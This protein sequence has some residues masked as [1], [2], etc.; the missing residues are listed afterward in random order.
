MN[1]M[2]YWEIYLLCSVLLEKLDELPGTNGYK[3]KMKMHANGMVKEIEKFDK[4][5][6]SQVK[7]SD[8]DGFQKSFSILND[9]L[10]KTHPTE[11]PRK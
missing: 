2:L 3:Q 9:A 6:A 8:Y 11:K 5:V 4:N 1:D 7:A 10:A